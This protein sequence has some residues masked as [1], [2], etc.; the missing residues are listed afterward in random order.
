MVNSVKLLDKVQV[1]KYIY[2]LELLVSKQIEITIFEN[3]FLQIRREDTYWMSDI[4]DRR[5][6]KILDTFFLDVDAYNPNELFDP[7]DKFNINETELRKRATET[8][9]KL[10]ELIAGNG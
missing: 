8:L 1:Q 6:G 7:N 5:V 2:M 4:F 10:K 3:L 9:I